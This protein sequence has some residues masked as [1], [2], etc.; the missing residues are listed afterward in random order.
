MPKTKQT[1]V[2]PN[3]GNRA[4]QVLLSSS[5]GTENITIYDVK[6]GVSSSEEMEAYNYFVQCSTCMG[7]SIYSDYEFYDNPG[8]L[9]EAHLIYP[10]IKSLFGVPEAI[11]GSY[12]EAKKVEKISPTAF[13]VL[14]R[15]AVEYL[16]KD[17]KASG[18][19]LKE[20]LEDLAKKN[21]IPATL[22]RMA[23]AIRYFG[24]IGAHS[25]KIGV[26]KDEV[27]AMDDFFLAIVEYVYIAPE[28]LNKLSE[29]IKVKKR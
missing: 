10:S 29:K 24:N 22:S 2:C 14:I 11:R 1:L 25:T 6:T 7:I 18:Y 3:C 20:K 8:N 12:K 5:K 21:I 16:C 19:T 13:A 17:Q 26:S 9:E 15:R 27:E 28:K 4:P 23:N